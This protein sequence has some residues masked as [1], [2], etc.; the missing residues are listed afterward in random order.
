M[1]YV[2]DC[3]LKRYKSVFICLLF[4]KKKFVNFLVNYDNIFFKIF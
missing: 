1:K 2:N 4:D 3:L